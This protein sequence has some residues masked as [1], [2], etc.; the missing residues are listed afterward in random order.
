[1]RTF[2]IVLSVLLLISPALAQRPRA[3]DEAGPLGIPFTSR[4]LAAATVGL[5]FD[6]EQKSAAKSLFDG[7]RAAFMDATKKTNAAI[8]GQAKDA[9]GVRPEAKVEHVAQFVEAIHGLETR[10]LEDL[11]ALC[12]PAQAEKLPSVERA[13]RRRKGFRFALAAGEGIDIPEILAELKVDAAGVPGAPDVLARWEEDVDKIM[14][15]KDQYMRTQFA[16]MIGPGDERKNKDRQDFVRDLMKMSGRVRDINKR[17]VRELEPLL[18]EAVQPA[19]RHAVNVRTFPRIYGASK[20]EK[21]IDACLRLGDVSA[22]QK[23][24]LEE[25]KTAYAKEAAP[26]N[27][28]FA[29]AAL[30]MQEKMADDIDGLMMGGEDPKVPFWAVQKERHELDDRT[31]AKAQGIVTKEQ[32]AGVKQPEQD[33]MP[34]FLPD[35]SEMERGIQEEF[36]DE[37]EPP[38]QPAPPPVQRKP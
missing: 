15:E 24:A 14:V 29:A 36:G 17:G 4:D 18:P 20:A 13:L 33:N 25:L 34:E 19:F 9:D 3:V 26:I 30:E 27:T 6:A 22:E 1:M 28:R 23:A 5:G 12:T 16:K 35:I 38:A 32:W 10:L 11:S 37:D 8:E 21:V 7:Y 31:V 2:A